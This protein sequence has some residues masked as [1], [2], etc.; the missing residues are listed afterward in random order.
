MFGMGGNLPMACFARSALPRQAV[1]DGRLSMATTIQ[2][3]PRLSS[4]PAVTA[5]QWLRQWTPADESGF[6]GSEFKTA[7]V[8]CAG[9]GDMFKGAAI[10]PG[11]H[12]PGGGFL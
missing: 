8:S 7:I 1:P 6:E 9:S 11:I 3:L 2:S 12:R 4:R 10:S 5:A